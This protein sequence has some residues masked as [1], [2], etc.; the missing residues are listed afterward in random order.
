ME[1][2]WF[3]LFVASVLAFVGFRQWLRH[4][5]R[6]M[7]HRERLAALEKGADLP[8]WPDESPSR[9]DFGLDSILLLSGLIWLAI[10]LGGMFAAWLIVSASDGAADPRCGPAVHRAHRGAG[11]LDRRRPPDRLRGPPARQ[12]MMAPLRILAAVV[13][14]AAAQPVAQPAATDPAATVQA[15]DDA[16]WQRLQRLRHEGVPRFLQQRRRVLPRPRRTDDRRSRPSTPHWRRTCAAAATGC[17]ARRSQ[18]TVRLVDPPQRRHRLRRDRRRRAR[19]LRAPAGQAGV[20]RRARPFR[21]P[22]AAEGRRVEDGAA[23]QLRPRSGHAALS[24]AAARRQAARTDPKICSIT[25][26]TTPVTETYSQIGNVHRA[27]RRWAAK[28]PES[29]R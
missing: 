28:R 11:R 10:G 23:P 14:L 17:A 26:T 24:P 18:G 20:P 21:Q 13:S 2:V 5:Q 19:L 25:K 1:Y 22:V 12:P 4:Q 3:P 9:F 15:R 6:A 7:V 29:D 16:F 27:T 8:A